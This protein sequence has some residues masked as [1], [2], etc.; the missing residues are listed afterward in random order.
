VRITIA[1]CYVAPFGFL[2]GMPFPTGLRHAAEVSESLV[3]WAWAVNGG[4]SVLG[5]VVAVVVSM[6]AGFSTSLTLGAVAYCGAL[7]IV[8]SL[9]R[10]PR[11]R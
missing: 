1:A 6:T 4:M 8:A 9:A 3:P 10:F 5:T 7:L 2:M 11:P